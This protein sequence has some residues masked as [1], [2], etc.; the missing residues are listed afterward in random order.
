[1]A[2]EASL[3]LRPMRM[4]QILDQAARLYRSNFIPFMGIVALV[5]VPVAVIQILL[6]LATVPDSDFVDVSA[7]LGVSLLSTLLS[8]IFVQGIGTAAMTRAVADNYLG[9]RTG[10][11]EAYRKIG[12]AW[13]SLLAALFILGLIGIVAAL[14]LL[15]P[16]VGWFTGLGI[17]FYLSLVIAPLVAPIIVLERGSASEGWRRAWELARQRFWWT[18]G[19]FAILNIFNLLVVIGPSTLVVY[20]LTFVWGFSGSDPAVSVTG[21]IVI[22]QLVTVLLSLVFLPFQLAATTLVYFDLRVRSEGFDLAVRAQDGD[23]EKRVAAE[24]MSG[25]PQANQDSLLTARE[26]GYFAGLTLIPVGL[27]FV[28]IFL[29]A[30][31]I[32]IVQGLS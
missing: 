22:Q 12:G 11:L 29:F 2:V 19:F 18:F 16:C 23:G 21:Q 7:T 28:F 20:I 1:M 14:W 15:V 5:Q 25:A 9:E 27:Y 26:M 17:I 4:G 6:N 10:A 3:N 8:F 30:I 13:L 24:L 31:L 32:G